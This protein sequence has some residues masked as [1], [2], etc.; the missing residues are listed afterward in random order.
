MLDVFRAVPIE[1]SGSENENGTTEVE[2][3]EEEKEADDDDDDD[4][5]VS[6]KDEEDDSRLLD[7][8]ERRDVVELVEEMDA[9]ERRCFEGDEGVSMLIEGEE[10]SELALL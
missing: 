8:V 3:E 10:E 7:V 2:E 6:N 1:V 4:V 9:V 5:D